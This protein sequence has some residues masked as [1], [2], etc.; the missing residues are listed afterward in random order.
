MKLTKDEVYTIKLA[1]GEEY[2]VKVVEDG[3]TYF[4]GAKPATL[5]Q[6]HDGSAQ[7]VPALL[8]AD[9]DKDVVINKG[10][11]VM[12][13]LT[14]SSTAEGYRTAISGIATPSKSI[15]MG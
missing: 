14:R 6:T 4:V 10:Q 3:D 8:T 5:V 2:V 11:V 13:V 12:A 1:S 9:H 7:L 15:I